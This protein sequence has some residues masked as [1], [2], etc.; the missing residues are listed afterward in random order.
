MIML[1]RTD[2][3]NGDFACPVCGQD[4]ELDDID[5]KQFV[6]TDELVTCPNCLNSL[7]ITATRITTVSLYNSPS[8]VQV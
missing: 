8:L 6:Y 2:K 4:F 7:T 5:G 1:C 3:G